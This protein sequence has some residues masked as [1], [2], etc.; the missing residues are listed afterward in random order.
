MPKGHVVCV[1]SATTISKKK[2]QRVYNDP[3]YI[4]KGKLPPVERMKSRSRLL[5]VRAVFAWTLYAAVSPFS[6][7]QPRN[8]PSRLGLQYS[9][10]RAL[11]HGKHTKH[12]N[13]M[14]SDVYGINLY[15]VTN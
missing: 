5:Q 3:D 4:S 12:R 11:F 6:D 14:F 9:N 2:A 8:A 1:G 15:V 7:K 13:P 10:S